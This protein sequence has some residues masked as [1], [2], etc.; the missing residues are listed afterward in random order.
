MPSVI[1]IWVLVQSF[2]LWVQYHLGPRSIGP[3]PKQ[4][5][6]KGLVSVNVRVIPFVRVCVLSIAKPQNKKIKVPEATCQMK[7]VVQRLRLKALT[8]CILWVFD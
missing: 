6:A 5:W 7:F 4:I 1:L 8:L 3:G 2:G